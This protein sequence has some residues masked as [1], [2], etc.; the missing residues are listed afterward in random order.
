MTITLRRREKASPPTP[1]TG[2]QYRKSPLTSF[3]SRYSRWSPA[4]Y[5]TKIFVFASMS[6]A[7]P[8]LLRRSR[9]ALLTTMQTYMM[10]RAL[11]S[12]GM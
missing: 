6:R 9:S 11:P 2:I 10:V 5:A 4:L 3:C 1:S 8:M 12:S 7:A